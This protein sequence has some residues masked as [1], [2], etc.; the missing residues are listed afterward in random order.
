MTFHDNDG[1]VARPAPGRKRIGFSRWAELS[2]GVLLLTALL[3]IATPAVAIRAQGHALSGK[4]FQAHLREEFHRLEA[5][6]EESRGESPTESQAESLAQAEMALAGLLARNSPEAVEAYREAATPRERRQWL[7]LMGLSGQRDFLPLLHEVL[8]EGR[9]ADGDG[10]LAGEALREV[11]LLGDPSS[12]AVLKPML[13]GPSSG[14]GNAGGVVAALRFFKAHPRLLTREDLRPL[15]GDPDPAVRMNLL[16][17]L[18]HFADRETRRLCSSGLR[19]AALRDGAMGRGEHAPDF[20]TALPPLRVRAARCLGRMGMEK[21]HAREALEALS[22]AFPGT[23]EAVQV[24]I[25]TALGSTV[26]LGRE[27]RLGAWLRH[28]RQRVAFSAL[29]ALQRAALPGAVPRLMRLIESGESPIPR[30]VLIK[31]LGLYGDPRSVDFLGAR[32]QGRGTGLPEKLALLE[33]LGDAGRLEGQIHLAPYLSD[34]DP[35]LRE[36]A[37]KALQKIAARPSR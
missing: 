22:Q 30:G 15:F 26:A 35:A 5:V 10:S 20:R 11:V 32:L 37:R 13:R 27:K 24:E 34:Y 7:R 21:A 1:A 14:R 2:L 28:G 16:D 12:A 18:P 23:E 8:R 31:S 36:T 3:M 19:G 6:R 25:V 29:V 33:A 9:V 4:E 17:L